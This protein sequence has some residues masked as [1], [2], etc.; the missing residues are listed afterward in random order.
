MNSEPRQ[1]AAR[2][3]VPEIVTTD[4][5]VEEVRPEIRT[6]CQLRIGDFAL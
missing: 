5:R 1:E 2:S 6:V 3:K 4:R